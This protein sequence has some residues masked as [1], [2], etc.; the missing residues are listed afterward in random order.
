L[1]F[2]RCRRH[3]KNRSNRVVRNG[4]NNIISEECFKGG[5]RENSEWPI[6]SDEGDES[7]AEGE[8]NGCKMG[9]FRD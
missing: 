9:N 4:F 5:S 3:T 7:G 1:A 6:E 2:G 8:D